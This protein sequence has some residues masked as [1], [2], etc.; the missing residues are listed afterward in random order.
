MTHGN[1]VFI[2]GFIKL[3]NL[4]I[5]KK[6]SAKHHNLNVIKSNLPLHGVYM[7][8]Q[9]SNTGKKVL[10]KLYRGL[11]INIFSLL[12]DLEIFEPLVNL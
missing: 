5:C 3:F 11:G 1:Y 2:E 6:A 10:R 4:N 8:T 7:Y 9:N 12:F